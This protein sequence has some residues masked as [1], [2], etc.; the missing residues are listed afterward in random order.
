MILWMWYLW[1]FPNKK[2]IINK[3]L[4][5]KKRIEKE[6]GENKKNCMPKSVNYVKMKWSGPVCFLPLLTLKHAGDEKEVYNHMDH[7]YISH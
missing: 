6:K 5:K 3:C 7:I 2:C 1:Q 4:C